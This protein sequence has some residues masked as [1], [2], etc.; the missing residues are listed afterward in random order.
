MT[1]IALGT[2]PPRGGTWRRRYLVALGWSFAFF[3]SARLLAY[4][5]TLA[6]VLTSRDS[7]QHSLWTWGIWFGANVTMA[8]WL[9]ER[10]G[11]RADRAVLVQAGNALMC[12]ALTIS[13]GLD[14]LP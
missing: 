14:R 8:A 1:D 9:Y 11:R 2:V 4:L 3:S 7:S 13:I 12:A 5:P 6:A 10:A